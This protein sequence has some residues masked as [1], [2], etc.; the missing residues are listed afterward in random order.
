[1]SVE[2]P[3]GEMHPTTTA[4]PASQSGDE[5]DGLSLHALAV[6]AD[7]TLAGLAGSVAVDGSGW[8]SDAA[9]YDSHVA[10]V[11]DPD[12]LPDM[13]NMLDL[14]TVSHDLFDVPAI[15]IGGIV[16]DSTAT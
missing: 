3:V 15:D 1:M 8:Q 9:S 2:N 6:A 4:D 5:A 13:D 10:L 7:P 11:L 16:G 14:L 12:V